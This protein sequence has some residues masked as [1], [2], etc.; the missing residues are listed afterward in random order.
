MNRP[1][2]VEPQSF[3]VS[4]QPLYLI[5]GIAALVF[6][7]MVLVPVV[8]VFAA[9]LPP[10]EGRALL[11]Y[12][13]DHR[14]LYLIQLICFVG[15]AVPALVVFVATAMAMAGVSR[16][17]ALLG[18]VLG[19]VSETVALAVGSSPQSLHGGLVVLSD[20]YLVADSDARRASLVTA[21]E[22]LI[23]TANGMPWAGVLTA[24]AI[25]TLSLV[26]R[27]AGF[28]TALAVLGIVTGALGIVAEVLRPMLGAGYAVY[29]LLLPVWFGWVGWNLMR[30]GRRPDPIASID[31][32]QGN[33][34]NLGAAGGREP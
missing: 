29:G 27:K 13:A 4:W 7:V 8:V 26:M 17:V 10:A 28:G 2:Q 32:R 6:V 20:A 1:T 23:A 22:G 5:G 9:P 21:A 31:G 15:L 33:V 34:R 11:E 25:L 3:D 19:T 30:L 14:A 18:G 12:I 16:S 24:A